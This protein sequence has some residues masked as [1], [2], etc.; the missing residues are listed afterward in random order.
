M[1]HPA[2]TVHVCH[3]MSCHCHTEAYVVMV[4]AR[5]A[6]ACH[7]MSCHGM[8]CHG[9]ATQKPC[10]PHEETD[11]AQFLG[12]GLHELPSPSGTLRPALHSDSDV[13]CSGGNPTQGLSPHGHV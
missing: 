1:Q 2:R 9:M 8:T 10:G 7:V 4:P 3:V 12:F 13:Q 5:T 6:H 11:E